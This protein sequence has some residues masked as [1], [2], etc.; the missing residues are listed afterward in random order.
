MAND[1]GFDLLV[2]DWDGT[3]A[4]SLGLIVR[5]VRHAIGQHAM[6]EK[7]D[8]EI[9]DIVGL[10][11]EQAMESLYPGIA[12]TDR[13]ALAASYREYY[14][15]VC[16]SEIVLF[17]QVEKTLQL[18]RA[19]GH[20]MAVATGKS[21]RG[22]DRALKDTGLQEYFNYSRCADETFSKP[23]PQMLEDIMDRYMIAHENVLMIGDSE[24]DLLMA[25]NAGVASVA[26]SY[27]A[28]NR[29]FL[30]KFEPLTCLS[31][32]SELPEW[33]ADRAVNGS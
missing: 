24:Y 25:K 17:P 2:F 19:R 33:L 10:G 32:F 23:H 16:R 8:Q 15:K 18:L 3:I 13:D 21:R 14:A 12:N 7:N 28:Q 1:A 27:G 29:E 26:V 11:L 9:K 31:S 22:L 5:S 30:L 20:S 4:D 6:P